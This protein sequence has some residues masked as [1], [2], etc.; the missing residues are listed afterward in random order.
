MVEIAETFAHEIGHIIG[1]YHD[2]DSKQN[3][4]HIT[5]NRT[6]GLSKWSSG[7]S[8][9][10]IMNYEQPRQPTWSDCSTEDF[11]NYYM[12]ITTK[13]NGEFCLKE[14]L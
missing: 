7:H 9:N 14:G 10:Q 4:P 13:Y 2:F 6:C 8:N 12:A 11:R 3:K 1:I 5:R